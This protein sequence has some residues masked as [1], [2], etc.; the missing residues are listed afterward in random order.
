MPVPLA[1]IGKQFSDKEAIMA[2][3]ATKE[4]PTFK[5][6]DPVGAVPHVNKSSQYDDLFKQVDALKENEPFLPVTMAA[7]NSALSL[8]RTA[9]DRGY[10]AEKRGLTVY[11]SQANGQPSK[12]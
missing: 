12:E 3:T 1:F 8:Q 11:L 5:V 4:A 10:G 9:K 7:D 6:G 2:R